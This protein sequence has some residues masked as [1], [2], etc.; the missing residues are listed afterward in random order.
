MYVC[1]CHTITDQEI[2]E[3]VDRG[4]RSLCEVQ[5]SLPVAGCCGQCEQ[6]AREVV[7]EHVATLSVARSA[8]LTDDGAGHRERYGEGP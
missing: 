6:V 8:W 2:R 4:A 5:S 1:I 3:A 7:D